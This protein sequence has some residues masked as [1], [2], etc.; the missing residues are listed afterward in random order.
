MLKKLFEKVMLFIKKHKII[1]AV[2]LAAF[3]GGIF[4]IFKFTGNAQTETKYVLAKAEKG[5]IVSSLS[6]SG[7]VSTLDQIDIKAK[8]SGDIVYVGAKEGDSVKAGKLIA[9]VDTTEAK[10]AI[11]T[12]QQNLE[13]AQISLKRLQGADGAAVPRNKQ[14]AID[15]LDKDYESA[16]NAIASAFVDLPA[17]VTDLTNTLYGSDMAGNKQNVSFYRDQIYI[18]KPEIDVFI[19]SAEDS[20]KK[21][22]ND[23]D[24][25]FLDY[26]EASRFSENSKI[27]S[28]LNETYETVKNVS[29]ANKDINNMLQVYKDTLADHNMA[30]D[31]KVDTAL[32]TLNSD[33]SKLNS[34][35]V[36]LLNS[37]NTLKNDKD[38]IDN[39]GLDLES[40]QLS[41][42]KSQNSLADAKTAL[43][44]YFIYAPFDG[45]IATMNAKTGQTAP[46][47]IATI[48]TKTM[49]AEI[50][51]GETDIAKIKIGQKATLTF[52][53]VEDLTISGKVSA[54]DVIGTSSQG[55]VSYNVKI[56][57]DVQDDRIK[58]GMSTT[59]T[60]II[61]T[62]T[63]ALYVPNSAV[64]TQQGA[65]YVLKVADTVADSDIQNTAGVILKTSPARQTVETGVSDDTSTEIT[66][67]L[68]EGDVVVSSTVAST[69]ATKTS[70]STKTTTGGGGPGGGIGIPGL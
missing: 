66:S 43:A 14:D 6:S 9:Q 61:D 56:V 41:V 36:S 44:D 40:Q 21:A 60:I 29:Q 57:M 64:K 49:V 69:S 3:I 67:G 54:I 70:T 42:Q 26:K 30:S 10:K 37:Q 33:A 22:D 12:A 51:F 55:V 35:I 18:Y 15:A 1:S 11:V 16:F 63:D 59:A 5:I 7:Q 34:A 68:S 38:A 62:K 17:I 28:L 27:D 32:S 65:K 58:S 23:F 52:D 47:P 8:V 50:S 2:I 53:A 39:A 24:N 45:V 13:S 19:K 31:T 48:V 20:Y 25:N 46:S 4:L